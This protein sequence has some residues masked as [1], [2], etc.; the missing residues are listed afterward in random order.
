[1]IAIDK[2]LKALAF[3]TKPFDAIFMKLLFNV[4]YRFV[5]SYCIDFWPL[6]QSTQHLLLGLRFQIYPQL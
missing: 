4:T 6:G 5:K 3:S 2:N 1:M